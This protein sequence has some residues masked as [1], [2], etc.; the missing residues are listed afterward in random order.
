MPT[1]ANYRQVRSLRVWG[2]LYLCAENV[3]G[4]RV[5]LDSDQLKIKQRPALTNEME[6]AQQASLVKSEWH[7]HPGPR[8]ILAFHERV[9]TAPVKDTSSP[10]STARSTVACSMSPPV[11]EIPQNGRPFLRALL[12]RNLTV[13]TGRLWVRP[14]DQLCQTEKDCIYSTAWADL[15]LFS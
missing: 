14:P 9:A 4:G 2:G 10:H 7:V 13:C 11:P 3:K 12:N 1:A 8:S 6:H 5:Q 15:K